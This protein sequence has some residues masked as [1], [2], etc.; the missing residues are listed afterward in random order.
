[1]KIWYQSFTHPALYPAYNRALAGLIAGLHE[2]STQV[3]IHCLEQSGG[4]AKQHHYLEH[5]QTT[6]VLDNVEKAVEAGYDAFAIGHFTDSGLQAAREI[7]SIPVLGLGESS[8]LTACMMGRKFSLVGINPKSLA[9]VADNV[10]AYGLSGR[11]AGVAAM[12]FDEP[13]ALEQGFS[14]A[15]A[16]K[17]VVDS[18]TQASDQT[19]AMGSEVIIPAGGIA[20]AML[21]V[22]GIHA[23]GR[24]ASVLNGIAALIK[25]AEMAARMNEFMGGRFTSKQ[26][27]YAPPT[28][29]EMEAIRQYHGTQVYRSLR[30]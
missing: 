2:P 5:L 9:C 17:R 23:V 10:H 25:C 26:L 29:S 30:R 22:A 19:L 20:M 27:S 15:A 1:M 8:M 18:F 21:T 4:L 14:D 3:D 24:G 12:V 16:R 13:S 28:L 11:L 7:A 6:E